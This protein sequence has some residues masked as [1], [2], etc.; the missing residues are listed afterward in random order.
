MGSGMKNENYEIDLPERNRVPE[1][2]IW[3][4]DELLA[5]TEHH[6]FEIQ[7][8]AFRRL[9]LQAPDQAEEV[10]ED[11]RD[12]PEIDTDVPET[13]ILRPEMEE[14]VVDN[15]VDRLRRSI[16]REE[17]EL[18]EIDQM[19]PGLEARVFYALSDERSLIERLF[20]GPQKWFGLLILQH[21]TRQWGP[22]VLQ[23]YFSLL[24]QIVPESLIRET[25]KQLGDP[26]L[27]PLLMDFR[28]PGDTKTALS[29]DFIAQLAG[30][31]DRLPEKIRNEAERVHEEL[32]EIGRDA[33]RDQE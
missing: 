6:S 32:R 17:E 27:I 13:A 16:E 24:N 33:M 31:Q 19:T 9:I 1:E 30:I 2:P 23:K 7:E 4:T 10:F 26:Q 11:F 18:P 29:L 28:E 5:F 15:L 12:R 14:E 3:T 25:A 20:Q 22:N 8:W 21:V